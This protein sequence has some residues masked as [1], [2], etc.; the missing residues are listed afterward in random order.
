MRECLEKN[1]N[2]HNEWQN[3]IQLYN[4]LKD[5][6]QKI[7]N[8]PKKKNKI[9]WNEFRIITKEFNNKKNRFYKNQKIDFYLEQG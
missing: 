5:D 9:F 3:K 2:S 8:I 4:K 6:F 1:P 7:K